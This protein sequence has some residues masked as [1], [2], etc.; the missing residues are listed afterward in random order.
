MLGKTALN[1]FIKEI[2]KFCNV[3][4]KNLG[5]EGISLFLR[6]GADLKTD[7]YAAISES[8]LLKK[9]ILQDVRS[10]TLA[11]INKLN[12]ADLRKMYEIPAISEKLP[13]IKRLG[14]AMPSNVVKVIAESVEKEIQSQGHCNMF[15]IVFNIPI[16]LN[17]L[18][19][20]AL[21]KHYS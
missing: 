3:T 12:N 10:C 9:G 16:F 4:Q 1:N 17:M 7:D 14:I 13:S 15:N 6:N 21:V 8:N 19:V 2:K 20:Q 11:V 5:L 18:C